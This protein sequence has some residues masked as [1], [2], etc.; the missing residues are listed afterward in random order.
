MNATG[1]NAFRAVEETTEFKIEAAKID[2]A[3][4]VRR[5][6][7]EKEINNSQLA[8]RLGV[9]KP[10]VSKLLR[11]DTNM[12]IETMVKT[13][14]AV[15]GEFFVRI[16]RGNC[17]PRYFEVMKNDHRQAEAKKLRVA[18][19]IQVHRNNEWSIFYFGVNENEEKPLAA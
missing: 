16:A 1:R 5:L 15:G 8:E 10:M 13:S 19:N 18:K 9:S 7:D 3:L 4:E 14:V 2:F 11:G 12:T 6:M 17:N